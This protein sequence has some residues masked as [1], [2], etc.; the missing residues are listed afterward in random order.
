MCLRKSSA[1]VSL[2]NAGAKYLL[3]EYEK[4]LKDKPL[5]VIPTCVDLDKFVIWQGSILSS[6]IHS[7]VGTLLSGWF[8]T[9]WLSKWFSVVS[10]QDKSAKFEIISRDAEL[11]IRKALP[12]CMKAGSRLTISSASVSEMPRIFS[13]HSVTAMF[14]STGTGK[15]GSAPTRLAE[16]LASG[17]PVVANTGVGDLGEIITKNR[18]GVIVNSDSKQDLLSAYH[19]L[20]LLLKD[21]KL[22]MRCRK[23]AESIFS[24]NAA[25]CKYSEI[26]KS[27]SQLENKCAD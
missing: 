24:L 13:R 26:Y 7:C 10:E 11:D 9:D 17:T 12:F 21:E 4:E 8:L 25:V 22:P 20:N 5:L 27:L 3:C 16:A 1:I 6:T 19:E 14:F 18:V 15:F 23:T 2:T